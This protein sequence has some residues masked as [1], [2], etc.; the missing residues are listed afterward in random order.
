MLEFQQRKKQDFRLFKESKVHLK[1]ETILETNTDY[2]GIK[3][4]HKNSLL[5]KNYFKNNSLTKEEKKN[6]KSI[7]QEVYYVLL[8]FQF[9][10][11]IL[12]FLYFS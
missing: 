7:S 12:L 9:L 8:L 2:T 5:S 6:N 4:I 11:N 1:S 3:A 10:H